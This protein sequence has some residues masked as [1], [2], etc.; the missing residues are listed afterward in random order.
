MIK[1]SLGQDRDLCYTH[2][3]HPMC[4]LSRAVAARWFY[5]SVNPSR[6]RELYLLYAHPA[7]LAHSI[8][9]DLITSKVWYS[10]WF[11]TE[12]FT[13]G[14]RAWLTHTRYANSTN[15]T[16]RQ[17]QV[18]SESSAGQI[19][20][21]WHPGCAHMRDA[22]PSPSL[23]WDFKTPEFRRNYRATYGIVTRGPIQS[24]HSI[25][26]KAAQQFLPEASIGLRVLSLPA[27]VCMCVCPSI[28][29]LSVR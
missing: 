3:C 8:A 7:V 1:P 23:A 16:V 19:M 27:C 26:I 9:I 14:L 20:G 12:L 24:I 6:H 15:Q 18:H 29:S 13:S 28:M 2:N 25:C 4:A 10:L 5:C 22:L 21:S 11:T 17:T